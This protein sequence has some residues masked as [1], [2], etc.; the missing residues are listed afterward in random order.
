MPTW[1]QHRIPLL[2]V[3]AGLILHYVL[4]QPAAALEP[5]NTFGITIHARGAFSLDPHAPAAPR[6]LGSFARFGLH[7]SNV[8]TLSKPFSRVLVNFESTVPSGTHV[9]V[10]VRARPAAGQWS[11]WTTD[12]VAGSTVSFDRSMRELQYRVVLL[13]SALHSPTVTALQLVPRAD[14]TPVRQAAANT[15]APTY[16]LRVT[17]QG[18]VGGRTAN[19]HII[20]KNDVYVSL[21]SWSVLSSKGGREY[22]VR[23]SANGKSIVA[24]VYDVGPWNRNDNFWDTKRKTYSDLP[25]GWPEDHAAYYE[26]Y[27]GR[28][29]EKGWV[30]FPTAV[31]VGDG[32]YWALGLKGGQATVNVTFLWLGDDPGAQ[33]RPR[34]DDPSHRPATNIEDDAPATAEP[35]P[36]E[37][38]IE[39]D[40]PI[41]AEPEPSAEAVEEVE[42]SAN[43]A[44]FDANTSAW[45][46]TTCAGEAPVRSLPGSETGAEAALWRPELQG[47]RYR[48]AVYVPLCAGMEPTTQTARFTIHT[49]DGS[50]QTVEVNQAST[51]GTWV[52]LGE[53]SFAAGD[54][55]FVKLT[56]AVPDAPHAIWFDAVRWQR[57][58]D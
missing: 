33:A 8:R 10:A 46:L 38:P 41:S 39:D 51:P 20:T 43:A 25:T 16:R 53:F 58:A 21:P 45:R 14:S 4:P 9:M 6:H 1:A 36:P 11:A 57:I 5:S 56:T 24:P 22:Q 54:D 29:A 35:E 26:G 49:S 19:G 40:A 48:V 15:V 31:D 37:E 12:I 32:A 55:G 7:D 23:L 17:R 27:N 52:T 42:I 2:L 18:M 50:E 44:G 13:G 34:N 30:K 3:C 28:M 47:G